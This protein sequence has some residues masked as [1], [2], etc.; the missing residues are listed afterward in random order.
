[1]SRMG[2]KPIKILENVKVKIDGNIIIVSGKNGEL[3]VEVPR[4]IKIE[5]RDDL[6]ILSRSKNDKLSKCIHGSIRKIII[7]AIDGVNTMFE[8][9]LDVIGVGYR[10]A[11]KG[12]DLELNVGYSHP[13]LVKKPENINFQVKKN[14]IT[15]SGADKQKVGQIAAQIREI[16]PP[17]P[18]KGKGIKYQDEIIKRKAGKAVKAAGSE[19]K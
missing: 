14:T 17:E 12:N 15:V 19:S 10:I 8:K 5:H 9:K 18:Y 3:K 11:L 2:N 16:R 4:Q 13:K 6:I 1:M 7:N